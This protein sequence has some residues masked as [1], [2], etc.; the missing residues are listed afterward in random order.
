[1]SNAALMSC[2]P[3]IAHGDPPVPSVE[4]A[5]LEY[6]ADVDGLRAVAVLSV[7]LF[8]GFPSLMPGGFVG[9]DIFFV[10]SGFLI[11]G[12]ILK[13]LRGGKF[14]YRE[15]Y[16]RR[17]GRIFPSLSLVLVVCLTV[18]WFVLFP[19]EYRQ[20]AKHTV[21]GT[22]FMSNLLLWHQ[23][24]YFDTAVRSKPLLHLWSLGIEEQFYIAWPLLLVL[25]WRW[26]KRISVFIAFVAASSFLLNIWL[27]SRW[28][29][30]TFYFPIT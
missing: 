15:F 16:A 20:L 7:L 12:I 27:I 25:L 19:D 13:G 6:R 30:L 8:H 9:V 14:S 26:T 24:G 1:M 3:R 11:T 10:I 2:D 17:I 23:A 28:P 5:D 18:G 21:A 4:K 29:S 22:L